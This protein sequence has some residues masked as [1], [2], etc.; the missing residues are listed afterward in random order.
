MNKLK[1]LVLVV[2]I[3][4]SSVISASTNPIKDAEPTS[5]SKTVG[6]L[7]ENPDFQLNKDVEAIVNI[8]VNEKDEMVV[9][10]VETDNKAVEKF[11]K[12]RLNYKKLSKQTT[13]KSFKVPVK[14][15]ES[16]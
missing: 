9:V 14:L 16:I 7:L 13:S 15:V 5:I 12:N 4:F 6:K 11:I 8:F 10:S 2:A 1:M 3:A